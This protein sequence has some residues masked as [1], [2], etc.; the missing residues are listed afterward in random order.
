MWKQRQKECWLD[1]RSGLKCCHRDKRDGKVLW[2]G[3]HCELLGKDAYAGSW[4]VSSVSSSPNSWCPPSSGSQRHNLPTPSPRTTQAH[5]PNNP[6]HHS[7]TCFCL[8]LLLCAPLWCHLL[9][10]LNS[11]LR[12]STHFQY[13]PKSQLL[14]SSFLAFGDSVKSKTQEEGMDI[15][16][17]LEH[18][19]WVCAHNVPISMPGFSVHHL[20]SLEKNHPWR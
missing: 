10:F 18:T 9:F 19:A 12:N 20:T 3:R 13:S 2:S 11:V 17:V 1:V 16:L 14:H 8:A 5:F 7:Q 4:S 15:Q 6:D